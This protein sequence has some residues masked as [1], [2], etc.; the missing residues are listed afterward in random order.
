MYYLEYWTLISIA[1][2]KQKTELNHA[3]RNMFLKLFKIDCT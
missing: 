3:R 1:Y 2:V